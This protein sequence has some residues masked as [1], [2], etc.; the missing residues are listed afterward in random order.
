MPIDGLV[1]GSLTATP[2]IAKGFGTPDTATASLTAS[3]YTMVPGTLITL[4]TALEVGSRF[5][6]IIGL[7]KTAAG[8]A[9]WNAVVSLGAHGTTADTQ[10]ATWT[11]GTNTAAI[12]QAILILEVVITALGAGTAAKAAC[13]AFYV[14]ELTTTTGLGNI[15]CAAGS[16]AGFNSAAAQY[17]HVDVEPGT[18]AVMTGWG[19]AE[20]LA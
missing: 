15:A 19:M 16:T 3:Q 2:G 10:V 12:D 4:N 17:I 11:S 9:T 6:F 14:N 7:L 20:Q 5:R 8:S 13:T 18:S 1:G